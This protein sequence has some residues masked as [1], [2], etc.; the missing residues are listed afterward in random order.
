MGFFIVSYKIILLK[1]TLMKRVKKVSIICVISL[2][3]QE[4]EYLV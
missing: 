2:S 4:T 3:I 1:N